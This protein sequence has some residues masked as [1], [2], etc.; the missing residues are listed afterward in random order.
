MPSRRGS[1]ADRAGSYRERRRAYRRLPS[2]GTRIHPSSWSWSVSAC[3]SV[4]VA[5]FLVPPLPAYS[6]STIAK[7]IQTL[8]LRFGVGI[9]IWNT[10]QSLVKDVDII[11]Y[12]NNFI[13]PDCLDCFFNLIR[14]SFFETY[15]EISLFFSGMMTVPSGLA[16]D[17]GSQSQHWPSEE[18]A[19]FIT[20][21]KA[22]WFQLFFVS[23]TGAA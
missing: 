8:A 18:H 20:G 17:I 23:N 14:E 2:R 21:V 6:P 9:A 13:V 12:W 7:R 5:G 16:S 4:K 3:W 10:R 11:W 15:L 22:F 19:V 1:L